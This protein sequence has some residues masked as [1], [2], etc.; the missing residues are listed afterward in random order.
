MPMPMGRQVGMG[1][2]P[3]NTRPTSANMSFFVFN[4]DPPR[5]LVS[6]PEAWMPSLALRGPPRGNKHDILLRVS[7]GLHCVACLQSSSLPGL[8]VSRYLSHTHQVISSA[9][10]ACSPIV[11]IR[12]RLPFRRFFNSP[13]FFPLYSDLNSTLDIHSHLSA[14]HHPICRILPGP[15]VRP[16]VRP[17]RPSWPIS[18]LAF[19][20]RPALCS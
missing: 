14:S 5:P 6:S 1:R 8:A 3:Q 18:I 9:P 2:A 15:I 11:T 17:I 7:A 19:T 10:S 16:L 4:L 20:T 13:F 12:T